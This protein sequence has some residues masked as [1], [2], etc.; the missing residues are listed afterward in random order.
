[1]VASTARNFR[2]LVDAFRI[3]PTLGIGRAAFLALDKHE[4]DKVKHV[5]F[6]TPA[7][8]KQSPSKRTTSE[9]THCNLIFLDIDDSKDAAPLFNNPETLYASLEG[10]SFAAHTTASS[11]PEKPRL[12]VVVDANHIPIADYPNAVATVG[13]MLGLHVVTKESRVAVQPMF[14]PTLFNDS[15]ED[16]HPLIAHRTDGRAFTVED[17]TASGENQKPMGKPIDPTDALD[18]LRAPVPEITLAIAKDALDAID[19]DCCRKEWIEAAQALKHQFCPHKEDE[20]LAL[21]DDWSSKGVKYGGEAEIHTQWRAI[22]Q[23]PV[24]RMPITIRSLLRMAVSSGWDDKRVKEAGFS[25][26]MRWL[27]EVETITELVETGVKKILATPLMSAVQEDILI[28]QLCSHAKKR[29]AYSITAS[30]IRKD[31]ARSKAEIK[32]RGK[33]AEEKR[34]PPWAK[35]VCYVSAT[36]EFYRHRTGEKYKSVAFDNCYSRWL[37]PTEAS[38]K[39][40]GIP[41]TPAALATPI[42]SP[43]DYAL[44][45]LKITT[46]YDYAYDPSQP[47]DVFFVN[48]GRW[49]VNTYS[50]TYPELD[51]SRAREAG[52]LFECHLRHII[53]EPGYRRVFTDFLAFHVQ[54]PGRKIRWA[55]LIQ[56]VEGAGKTFFAEAM[57]AVLGEEHVNTISGEAIKKGWNEWSFGSQLVVLEEVRVTGTNRHEIMNALKPLVT[58]DD[59][60]IN[61]RNRNT[62]QAPNISNY[63]AFSNHHN[64]LALSPGDRRWFVVKSPL[65]HK[66]QVLSLGENYFPKLFAMLRDMPGALRSWFMDWEISPDFNPDG[67]APRT[68]YVNDMV[69]D[70]ASDL[71]ASVRRLLLEGDYPL[72]QFDIVSAKVLLDV[73][74]LEDGISHIS[75]QALA[76]VLREEGFEQAGRHIIGEERHYLWAR[77]GIADAVDIAASRLDGD[78]KNLC[79][80]LIYG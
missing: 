23:S 60:S 78:V 57:K 37:L 5:P 10:L 49:F 44:N 17:I 28:Q 27:E 2:E 39:E 34:E 30:A 9:T 54:S 14:L 73:L 56:G 65:Q 77:K 25:G 24:G 53:A 31:I 68:H 35:G 8:F 74:H 36:G 46:V 3:C 76:Q 55:V 50:P 80:E 47:G 63:L 6:F 33:P 79:M 72:I 7:C 58:N 66:S 62:R 22:R 26:V 40:A 11:T 51:P 71:T 4:R 19:P 67:H 16:E 70:S 42:V 29:F 13:A 61:E 1:M 21:F 64:A 45:H 48:R 20:A 69:D 43:T 41:A 38:L 32:L 52:D 75:H 12:R 18:F 15:T 59:I